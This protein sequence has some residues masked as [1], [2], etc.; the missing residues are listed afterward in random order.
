[1]IPTFLLPLMSR[2]SI[3]GFV[4]A[5]VLSLLA[6]LC[7]WNI[8]LRKDVVII[9]NE[10]IV[11]EGKLTKANDKVAALEAEILSWNQYKDKVAEQQRE[12]AEEYAEQQS[13]S[14]EAM[15][16]LHSDL[17]KSKQGTVEKQKLIKALGD[18]C[19]AT[20]ESLDIYCEGAGLL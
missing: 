19:A 6:F 16:K 4:Y 8:M 2:F 14:R 15:A 1:M 20:Q 3:R 13:Q 18:V 10:K 9:G 11:V 17:A 5:V 7:V 12:Q